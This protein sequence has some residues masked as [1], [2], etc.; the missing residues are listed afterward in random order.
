MV[1]IQV[2]EEKI[3]LILDKNFQQFKQAEFDHLMSINK[4]QKLNLQ[5]AIEFL[6]NNGFKI[7]RSTIYKLTAKNEIPHSKFCSKLVFDRVELEG[8][9]LSKLAKS[10]GNE[11]D[12]I[13]KS[14][15]NKLKK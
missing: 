9:I 12:F 10:G 11:I 15:I 7:S 14:A 8:W 3:T 13:S 4:F 1:D 2:L 5:R 6:N